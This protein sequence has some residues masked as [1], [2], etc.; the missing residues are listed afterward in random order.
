MAFF[1]SNLRGLNAEDMK[2]IFKDGRLV[3]E[4]DYEDR[5]PVL[6]NENLS[7]KFDRYIAINIDWQQICRDD[8]RLSSLSI[9]VVNPDT[10]E[11]SLIFSKD[12]FEI[13]EHFCIDRESK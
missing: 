3:I 11:I 13:Y 2:S 6:I 1:I 5:L 10:S 12:D 7:S 9:E 8:V 4:N